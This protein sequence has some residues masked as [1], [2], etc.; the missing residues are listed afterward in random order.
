MEQAVATYRQLDSR[1]IVETVKALNLRVEKRFPNSGLGKISAEL[2][3]VAEEKYRAGAMDSETELSP[4]V[5]GIPDECDHDCGRDR[6]GG[7]YSSIP[8]D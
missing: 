3:R 6:H 7:A 4:T 5:R 1:E 8:D 2:L